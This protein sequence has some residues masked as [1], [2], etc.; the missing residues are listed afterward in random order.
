MVIHAFAV[1]ASCAD[2]TSSSFGSYV[3]LVKSVSVGYFGR[4]FRRLCGF[5]R[6]PRQS[7]SGLRFHMDGAGH[8]SGNATLLRGS[9]RFF[10]VVQRE[11]NYYY[12]SIVATRKNKQIYA[13]KTVLL[14]QRQ[15]ARRFGWISTK[16]NTVVRMFGSLLRW[17]YVCTGRFGR[18][19][20]LKFSILNLLIKIKIIIKVIRAG[21]YKKSNEI[22]MLRE[23]DFLCVVCRRVSP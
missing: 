20:R 17:P 5:Y 9:T 14:F 8:H 4:L 19:N 6:F 2:Q 21:A 22:I 18:R 12:F 13:A 11:R 3:H 23:R 7:A 15:R 16:L 10:V 1:R